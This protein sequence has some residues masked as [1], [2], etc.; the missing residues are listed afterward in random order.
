M[1]RRVEVDDKMQQGYSYELTARSGQDYAKDFAP[2]LTP[3]E[4]LEMGVF[5][6]CYMTDCRD[7]FPKSWFE[8]AKLSPGKPDK[9]L[10][11]YGIHASQ[12]LSEWRKKGWIHEDDPRGWFQWY[13]RY[14]M[15]R[16]HE[17][18]ARQIGRW[19]AMRRHVGQ[20][21]KGCDEGDLSCR[22]RQRQA[23]LHW[24]YDSRKL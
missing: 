3:K 11:Y 14:Y 12:P 15:G 19:R 13:C 1:A 21:R 10:N 5:G 2:D 24:A 16:R 20:V 6:G 23:L 8:S 18:D 9:T 7:E 22:P 17:D 4:M